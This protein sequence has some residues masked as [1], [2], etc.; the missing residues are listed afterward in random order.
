M[1]DRDVRLTITAKDDAS[2]VIDKVGKSLDKTGDSAESLVKQ[3]TKGITSAAEDAESELK[4]MA[5]TSEKLAH[6]LGPEL[7][8]KAG[9][10]VAEFRK[11]GATFDDIEANVD[12]VA[13]A[14]K[15]LDAVE[16]TARRVVA[17]MDDLGTAT[18]RVGT[19]ADRSR[20]VMANFMGNAAQDIPGVA[21]SMGALNVAVGQFAEYATEGGIAMSGLIASM[22]PIAASVV[23][24]QGIS[25]YM[26]DISRKK[27]F[28]REQ[29]EGWVQALRDGKTEIEHIR[30]IVDETGK[31]ETPVFGVEDLVPVFNR[32]GISAERYAEILKMSDDQLMDFVKTG[33]G[34]NK[35]WGE[36]ALLYEALQGAAHNYQDAV[37]DT[38]GALKFLGPTQEELNRIM[39][40]H[41]E[42][43]EG[44]ARS[45]AEVAHQYDAADAALL[46]LTDG[47]E[48]YTAAMRGGVVGGS[49]LGVIFGKV[50][51][52]AGEAATQIDDLTDALNRN[53]ETV[54]ALAN[55]ELALETAWDN[56]ETALNGVFEALKKG[57][58]E[59]ADDAMRNLKQSYLGVAEA[60]GRNAVEALG[61]N[62][63][64]SEKAKAKNDAMR[65]A[66]EE[67]G[68]TLAPGSPEYQALQGWIALLG[69]IPADK[70]TRIGATYV[71]N[72][73]GASV[74]GARR[75]F[76][77][78][79]TVPGPKGSPQLVVAHGGETFVPTHKPGFDTSKMGGPTY[80]VTINA[81]VGADGYAV[82][83]Q[84]VQAIK[85]YERHAG[86]GWRS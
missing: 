52:D 57:D 68:R 58:V 50:A 39:A 31:L 7:A 5:Q 61:E 51:T 32:A 80:N 9:Q 70:T 8:D 14:I 13:A 83:Q 4:A 28:N 75:G 86:T 18:H 20:S 73:P 79:G 10:I 65:G 49:E 25:T 63:S 45:Q 40:E 22:A 77:D 16:G 48:R 23:L 54:L 56:A 76:A 62:A 26:G 11:V 46:N 72:T 60:A 30:D 19:E 35:T 6:A 85:E 69:K 2:K 84:F 59:A 67:L 44:V 15:K 42:L 12:D 55:S 37:E 34:A 53:N 74:T 21:G 78:G 38:A 1:A 36:Q 64:E 17:P 66:L 33:I 24:F 82:G 3:L 41:R 27:A 47:V 43:A 29:V 81:G 71:G